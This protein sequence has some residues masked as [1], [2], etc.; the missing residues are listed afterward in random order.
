MVH[1]VTI[2]LEDIVQ[3]FAVKSL[4]VRGRIVR[5]GPMVDE[6]L[7]KHDYPE[8]VSLLLAEAVGLTAMLG[9]SLKFDGKFILQSRSDGPVDMLVA[10]YE[11][12]GLMRAYARFDKHAL[13]SLEAPTPSSLLGKGHLAMTVDQGAHMERYQGIVAL[14]GNSLEDAAHAYFRQSEQIPT[15]VRLSAGPLMERGGQKQWRAGGILIQHLPDE[16][17]ASPMIEDQGDVPEHL[18]TEGPEEDNRWVEARFLLETVEDHELLD[19]ALP[20]EGLLYRLFHEPGVTAWPANA[21][22]RHCTCSREKVSEMLGNFTPEERADMVE[23]GRI[24]V[25]C[26][27]CSSHYDFSLEDVGVKTH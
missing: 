9:A 19:P 2:V 10:Q 8:A 14:D 11:T 6:I 26:E 1:D 7:S 5:L 25:T 17:G 20:A 12:P 27:F 13:A 15:L 3:S 22:S 23:N 21:L 16:G 18:K 4:G 24:G